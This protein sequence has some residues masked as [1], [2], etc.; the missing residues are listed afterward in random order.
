METVSAVAV[1]PSSHC[2][3]RKLV[4]PVPKNAS[5][6][7]HCCR[8]CNAAEKTSSLSLSA[9]IAPRGTP[10]AAVGQIKRSLETRELIG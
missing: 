3:S 1:G 9:M 7:K 4:V 5:H 2:Q 8:L 6:G 10:P